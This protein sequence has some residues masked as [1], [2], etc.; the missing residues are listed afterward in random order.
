[1]SLI[2]MRTRRLNR[3]CEYVRNIL[4]NRDIDCDEA[5]WESMEAMNELRA[6]IDTDDLYITSSVKLGID[7]Q[8]DLF[9]FISFKKVRGGAELRNRVVE[10][11]SQLKKQLLKE[12]PDRG[13]LRVSMVCFVSHMKERIYLEKTLLSGEGREIRKEIRAVTGNKRDR[14]SFTCILDNDYNRMD[15]KLTGISRPKIIKMPFEKDLINSESV[16]ERVFH[17]RGYVLTAQLHQ[18]VEIYNRVGDR[19]FKNNVRFGLNEQM[20][21][22]RAIKETLRK[23]PEQFWFKNNGVTVLV[24]WPDFKLDR[25]EE[26]LLDHVEKYGE[27]HFSVINGAQ[28][29]TAAAEYFYGRDYDLKTCAD[30]KIREKMEQEIEASR[31]AGVL[32]RIIHIPSSQ[33]M[34]EQSKSVKEVNEI[35]VAL[36]RQKPIKSE[37]IAFASPFVD[38]MASF[39]LQKTGPEYFK[40]VKRGEGNALLNSMDLVE[41]ARARKACAK[42]PGDA[43]SKGT[44]SLLGFDYNSSQEAM[45]KDTDIFVEEWFDAKEEVEDCMF[46]KYY[47]AVNFAAQVAALYEREAKKVLRI[48][49]GDRQQVV[50]RNGKWY[51]TAYLVQLFNCFRSDFLQFGG[52]VENVKACMG[53][54][55]CLFADRVADIAE[56]QEE[57]SDWNSNIFKK[58]RLFIWLLQYLNWEEFAHKIN[59]SLPDGQE[60]VFKDDRNSERAADT[61]PAFYAEGK[62]RSIEL[63]H[64]ERIPV[65]SGAEAMVRSAEYI[66]NCYPVDVDIIRRTCGGWLNDD[67]TLVDFE[68]G[69]FR[70]KEKK[71]HAGGRTYWVGTSSNT[72]TKRE[73]VTQLCRQAGAPGGEIRW[74]GEDNAVIFAY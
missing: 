8:E 31:Q 46:R 19:L 13:L 45:F 44:D 17:R 2:E 35:S 43:R 56:T 60:I 67:F 11:V 14:V 50:V 9:L 21:V 7:L 68:K 48:S 62:V 36:N 65:E 61:D 20:G 26:I 59:A 16:K 28:T 3:C 47:G 30:E 66:L 23:N 73:Q 32:L 72:P 15:I 58:N 63:G 69:Y 10:M 27:L 5:W 29:I 22:D 70:G 74:F 40:L 34:T 37:D 18:L 1:M 53:A 38:Q 49:L 39:L 54:L 24:E 42:K 57:F 71:I 51:F 55:I 4:A 12:D 6:L 25:T 52:K 41:F 33:E 64:R